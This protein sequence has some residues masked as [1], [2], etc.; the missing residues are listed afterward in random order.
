[1]VARDDFTT[2]GS[3][4]PFDHA[5]AIVPHDVNDLTVVMRGFWIGTAG[6]LKVIM[7]GGETVVWP[8]L[9]VGYHPIR[10]SRVF[11]TGTTASGII[12]GW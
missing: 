10:A 12:G 4:Q 9:T 8:G 6:D 2:S 3:S 5:V 7:K 11:A 1:M